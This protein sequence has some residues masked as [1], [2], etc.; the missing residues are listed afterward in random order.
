MIRPAEPDEGVN[1]A[2]VDAAEHGAFYGRA[3]LG[4]G[5]WFW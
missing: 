3:L 1:N 4:L 5:L 2:A